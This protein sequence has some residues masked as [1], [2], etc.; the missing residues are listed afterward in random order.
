MKPHKIIYLLKEAGYNQTDVARMRGCA[1]SLVSRVI[2]NTNTS[3]PT[4]KVIAGLV[5]KPVEVLWPPVKK[6]C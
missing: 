2:Y 3:A 4:Q 1:K 5:G 6:A